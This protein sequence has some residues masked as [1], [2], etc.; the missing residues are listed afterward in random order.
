MTAFRGVREA[1]GRL[2]SPDSG[3]LVQGGRFALAGG[4]VAL[5]YVTVTTVLANGFGVGFQ[6]ALAIGYATAIAAH[7]SLQR[8]FVWVHHEEFALPFRTQVGR[9]L[10]VAGAQYAMAAVTTATLPALLHLPV[11]AVFL[12]WTIAVSAIGFLILGRG[13]F[14]ARPRRGIRGSPAGRR[15]VR[16]RMCP[17]LC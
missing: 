7:F 8:F 14:H 3:L 15:R 12:I 1:A 2:R 11:T 16:R 6:W 4:I 17:R 13:V 9:Y 5:I 10:L